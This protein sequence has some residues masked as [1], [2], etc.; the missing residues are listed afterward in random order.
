VSPASIALLTAGMGE[1]VETFRWLQRALE[2]HDPFLVYNFVGEP[3]LQPLK[4]RPEGQAILRAM[5]LQP[6]P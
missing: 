5:G 3:L 4:R 2:I 1:S 6:Q